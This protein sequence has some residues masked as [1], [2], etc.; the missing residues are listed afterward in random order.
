MDNKFDDIEISWMDEFTHK[1]P[2]QIEEKFRKYLNGRTPEKVE[3]GFKE[4]L[5][6][7]QINDMEVLGVSQES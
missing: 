1:D 5:K 4:K 2:Q 3:A 7:Y 6:R